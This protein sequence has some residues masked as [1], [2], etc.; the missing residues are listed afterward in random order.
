MNGFPE[1]AR[2][3]EDQDGVIMI[4]CACQSGGRCQAVTG[5]LDRSAPRHIH[6]TTVDHWIALNMADGVG[7]NVVRNGAGQLISVMPVPPFSINADGVPVGRR[8]ILRRHEDVS[9][10]SGTGIVT[11]G[12]EW[13]DG[14][15]S[16]RWRGANPSF[17]NWDSLGA[18]LA[19]HGHDGK[20]EVE[21]ID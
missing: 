17:A 1:S 5:M 11:Y 21:W 3:A 9:G 12:I 2:F 19:T 13:P 4:S 14:T 18:V 8:F 20:T 6:R 10:V 16:L 15:I 7:Y